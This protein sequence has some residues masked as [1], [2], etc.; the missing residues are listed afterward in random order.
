MDDGRRHQKAVVEAEQGGE[1]GTR[2]HC[3]HGRY[4]VWCD[5]MSVGKKDDPN[6]DGVRV[7]IWSTLYHRE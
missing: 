4:A 6:F 7:Y 5:M 1:G 3:G 2:A